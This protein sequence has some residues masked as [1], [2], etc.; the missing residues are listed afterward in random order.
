MHLISVAF[1]R[2]E[3]QDKYQ[4]TC[5]NSCRCFCDAWCKNAWC[6][7][8]FTHSFGDSLLLSQLNIANLL[9]HAGYAWSRWFFFGG[10]FV[11]FFFSL[12][13][14]EEIND[15]SLPCSFLS[16]VTRAREGGQ[17]QVPCRWKWSW[18]FRVSWG[19]VQCNNQR[20]YNA[21]VIKKEHWFQERNEGKV[22]L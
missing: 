12:L 5:E 7:S 10:F 22:S 9:E 19:E 18:D 2:Q 21:K 1:E 14:N 8:T 3:Q 17:A 20:Y 13:E 6:K 16:E 15:C 11:G 4:P